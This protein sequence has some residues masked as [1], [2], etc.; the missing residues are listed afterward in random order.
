MSAKSNQRVEEL[1][2][3]LTRKIIQKLPEQPMVENTILMESEKEIKK[4]KKS[5]CC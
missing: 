3:Q 5:N 4:K 2:E 1:F